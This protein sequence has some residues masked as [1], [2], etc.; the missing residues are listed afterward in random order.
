MV[1][2]G[3]PKMFYLQMFILSFGDCN[4]ICACL[5]ETDQ[6]Y[7]HAACFHEL[8]IPKL[9]I[10]SHILHTLYFLERSVSEDLLLPG[11]CN[12]IKILKKGSTSNF[13]FL[14]KKGEG[15]QTGC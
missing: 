1:W 14:F 5:H 3:A 2:S 12:F 10:I 11:Q 13:I 9:L 4:K 6:W 8:S 15:C 7:L